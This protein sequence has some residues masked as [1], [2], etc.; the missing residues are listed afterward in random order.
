MSIPSEYHIDVIKS[1]QTLQ[2]TLSHLRHVLQKDNNLPAWFQ[3]PVGLPILPAWDDRHKLMTLIAQC[4]YLDHQQPRDIL[5]GA[6]LVA[7]SVDTLHAIQQL[8]HAKNI[9]KTAILALKTAKISR[10]DPYLTEQFEQVLSS[11][12]YPNSGIP[13]Q[14]GRKVLRKIGLPRLHLKQCY[15]SIPILPTRPLKVS[16][17]WANTKAITCI[18]IQEAEALLLKQGNDVGIQKQ[19]SKLYALPPN[20][21]LAIVQELAPHLRVNI[22]L[23]TKA[24]EKT[25]IMV[26]GPVPLFYPYA[27]DEPLPLPDIRPPGEKQ[28]KKAD[29]PIRS[30][31]KLDPEPFLPAIRVHRYLK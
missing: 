8:N 7:A 23:P 19:L 25:R 21:P 1:F 14:L 31:V 29:R 13:S 12:S 9:F 16:W 26:K 4:E 17:T 27:Y 15:R 30:D 24:G 3:P 20:T 10:A 5:V 6:G 2:H 28:G 22:V 11:P 18:T